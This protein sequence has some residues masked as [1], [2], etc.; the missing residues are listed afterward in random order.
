VQATEYQITK[1]TKAELQN[2][3][4]AVH[5]VPCACQFYSGREFLQNIDDCLQNAILTNYTNDNKQCL[6]SRDNKY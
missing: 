3:R 4:F 5:I 2:Y 1:Q 6:F